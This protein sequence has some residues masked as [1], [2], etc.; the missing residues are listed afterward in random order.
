M[1]A[2]MPSGID[3]TRLIDG[4][5]RRRHLPPAYFYLYL[6]GSAAIEPYLARPLPAGRR[7]WASLAYEHERHVGDRFAACARKLPALDGT[8]DTARKTR[9]ALRGAGH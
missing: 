2:T 7:T 9:I 5:D 3:R 1:I 8:L 6:Q 4:V